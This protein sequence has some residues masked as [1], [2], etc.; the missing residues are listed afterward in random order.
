MYSNDFKECNARTS[1]ALS[2]FFDS[3][4]QNIWNSIDNRQDLHRMSQGDAQMEG[5]HGAGAEADSACVLSESQEAS[6]YKSSSP[7]AR[8]IYGY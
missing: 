2:F 5:I 3:P 6:D 8:T 4:I 1:F 7:S